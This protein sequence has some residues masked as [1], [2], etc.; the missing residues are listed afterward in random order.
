M[1]A[2]DLGK[3]E[4][5]LGELP[6]KMGDLEE[7]DVLALA[8]KELEAGTDP[9]ASLEA[10]HE[11]MG[12]VGS[13]FE[14]KEYFVAE[15]MMAAAVFIQVAAMVTP[16]LKAGAGPSKGMVIFG[17]VQTDIQ[18]CGFLICIKGLDRKQHPGKI[19]CRGAGGR[20]LIPKPGQFA[21]VRGH[22]GSVP[23]HLS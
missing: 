19:C 9:Q 6:T 22:E 23:V 4:H 18:N 16:R 7:P 11:G 10:C 2:I 3:E 8:Q 1:F 5:L 14:N 12:I 20:S 21:G 13:R 17:T 15:L